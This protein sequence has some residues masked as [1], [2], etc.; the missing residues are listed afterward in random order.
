MT[1]AIKTKIKICGLNDEISVRA[2]IKS[3]ADY[4][5][6]VH[7]SKSPRHVSIAQVT[8]LKSLLPASVKSVMVLVNPTDELLAEIA[9]EMQPDFFQLHGDEIPER[10]REIHKKFPQ[11]KLIKAISVR[12][13]D[14]IKKSENFYDVADFLLFDAKPTNSNMMH[15]GN[16]ISFDWSLLAGNTPPIPIPINWFLSGGLNVEN[17]TDAIQQTGAKFL[18]VS[19]GVEK[20]AGVKSAE[21]I[22]NFVKVARK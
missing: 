5:G 12:N 4:A 16:G 2:V 19:S 15:G 17:I 8:N 7:Y 13:S 1:I 21:L 11:I 18:D 14:D 20:S 3:A 22:E 6:F 10:L 9:R